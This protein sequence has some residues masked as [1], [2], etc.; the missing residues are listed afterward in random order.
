MW[1]DVLLLEAGM[2]RKRLRG[3]WS[4]LVR[5][6]QARAAK[7]AACPARVRVEQLEDRL[8]PS[9]TPTV[10]LTTHGAAGAANGALFRQFDAQPTGTG[11]IN[12]FVRLQAAN[13][14]V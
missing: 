8:V 9:G 2:A 7:P 6:G 3:W 11:V 13:A 5:A 1:R 12:S 14:K 4:S 10:D